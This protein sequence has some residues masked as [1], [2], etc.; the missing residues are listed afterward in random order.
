MQNYYTYDDLDVIKEQI[1]NLFKENKIIHVNVNE[2][3]IKKNNCESTITGVY[4]HFFCVSSKVNKYLEDFS[5]R[6]SDI[7]SGKYSIVE[8]E[9]K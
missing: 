6:Y 2:K 7:K 3:R 1:A 8:L 4:Q 5:I 9:A